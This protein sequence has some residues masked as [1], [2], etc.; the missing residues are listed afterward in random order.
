MPAPV[1][2]PRCDSEYTL[3]LPKGR[4]CQKCGVTFGLNEETTDETQGDD[5]EYLSFFR[6][7]ILLG[8]IQGL[9][10]PEEIVVHARSELRKA[11]SRQLNYYLGR[12]LCDTFDAECGGLPETAFQTLEWFDS[13]YPAGDPLRGSLRFLERD[14]NRFLHRR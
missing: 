7:A 5:V 6:D 11:Y 9:R 2:C 4:V 10:R 12:F 1:N 3:P 14:I 13:H 8:Y